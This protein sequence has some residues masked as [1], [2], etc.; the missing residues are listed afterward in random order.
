MIPQTPCF[1]LGIH[2]PSWLERVDI[3]LFVSRRRL[4]RLKRLPRAI[5]PWALD[6][7]GFSE[8]SLHGRFELPPAAYAAEVRRYRDEIGGLAWAAPQDWMCEPAMLAR[9]GLSVDEH[10]RRT[11]ANYL[12]LRQIAPEIPWIPV[13]QG[14]SAWSAAGRREPPLLGHRHRN[15]A[16]CL[17]FALAWRERL[18]DEWVGKTRSCA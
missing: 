6:S 2:E 12:E 14:W 15:C 18:P 8:L 4:G 7:G 16:N 9:T 1:W 3:P 10:Q 17:E 5:G 13:L 11:V